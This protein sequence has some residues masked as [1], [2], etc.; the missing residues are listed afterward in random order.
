MPQR[1]LLACAVV[2]LL[3]CSH[4]E[5]FETPATGSD[6]PFLP[7]TPTRLTYNPGKDLHPAWTADGETFFYA[8]EQ[9]AQPDRDR[10]LG[11]LPATG[12]S[13]LR[14]IC[15]PNP[16]A[17]DSADF[18]DAPS[19]SP[20]GRL[21]YVRAT[22][23]RG[24]P[25]VSVGSLVLGRLEEPLEGTT[26]GSV[27]YTIPG[28]RTHGG[29][30]TARWADATHLYYVGQAVVYGRQANGYPFDTLVTGLEIVEM[31]LGGALPARSVVP[32]TYGASSVALNDGRDTLYYTLNNDSLVYR[33]VLASGTVT[34]AHDFGARGIA[35]D[36]TVRGNQLVAV[37]GG[38]VLYVD[39]P[40]L[41][42]L[43]LDGG[44][45]LVSVN[46]DSGEE[47]DLP[48]DTPLLFRHPEFAPGT[49]PA[50]LVAEGVPPMP[51]P[52]PVSWHDYASR[53]PE[54]YLFEAP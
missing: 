31:V 24:A 53:V 5:P 3:G 18:F 16:A 23:P 33:R 2:I 40:T 29:L 38:E 19:P 44:G 39:D 50:R 9:S 12:G 48:T 34:V 4:E 21:L 13:R 1:S 22:S 11:E 27:P 15:N 47:A 41:G 10:C 52:G 25:T 8:W 14:V 45:A 35:R 20:D 43:Q 30:S 28:G 37:V 51:P 32:G 17:A 7:G 46:L 26:L 54:L 36:V 6:A 49:L 42:P